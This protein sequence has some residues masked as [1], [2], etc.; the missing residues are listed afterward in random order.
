MI[1]PS[2]LV[3]GFAFAAAALLTLACGDGSTDPVVPLSLYASGFAERGGELELRLMRGPNSAPL[4][5]VSVTSS[6][7]EIATVSGDIA[8]LH[9]VGTVTFSATVAGQKLST[10]VYVDLPP[11]IVFEKVV[12]GNRD[13]Y[14]VYLDGEGLQQ[15][16]TS[17]ADDRSPSAASGRVIFSSTR[18]GLTDIYA[19][20]TPGNECERV[21]TTSTL[22]EIEPALSPDGSSIAF[23]G[24]EAGSLSVGKLYLANGDGT[25]AH[26]VT[27]TFGTAGSLEATPSWGPN[28]DRVAFV[29][30]HDG[31]ADIWA[32]YVAGDSIR[33]LVQSSAADVEP[34]W[35]PFNDVAFVSNRD[36][37]DGDLYLL[38]LF[39]GHSTRLTTRAGADA[40]PSWLPDGRIVF[41]AYQGTVATL[42]WLDVFSP[43]VIHPIPTGSGDSRKAVSI[44]WVP[45]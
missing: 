18:A 36:D 11:M 12:S 9:S 40:Q 7:P 23:I 27:T 1:Q 3:T 28:A 6:A 16:S 13:L 14:T 45:R 4:P 24:S 35:G 44:H 41:T 21:T 25:G 31:S 43:E 30:T 26:R 17:T 15:V 33:P 22:S 39:S 8:H 10:T 19:I 42:A 20:V 29:T 38:D 2:R 32:Y 5:A 34:A 37:A